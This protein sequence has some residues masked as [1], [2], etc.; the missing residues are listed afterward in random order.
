M[1]IIFFTLLV[2]SML[3]SCK[4]QY[5]EKVLIDPKTNETYSIQS[6]WDG[7]Y[8]IVKTEIPRDSL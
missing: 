7:A 4:R 8:E 1:K 6:T 2:C 3:L 5:D